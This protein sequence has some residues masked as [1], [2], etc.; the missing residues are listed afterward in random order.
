MVDY[1]LMLTAELELKCQALNGVN[2]PKCTLSNTSIYT[3]ALRVCCIASQKL[4]ADLDKLYCSPVCTSGKYHE[5][6]SPI[7]TEMRER[8]RNILKWHGVNA[9]QYTT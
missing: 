1:G 4:Q 8:E 7:G 2:Q 9:K 3:V 5:H 6:Y